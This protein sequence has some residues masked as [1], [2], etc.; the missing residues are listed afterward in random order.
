[1]DKSPVFGIASQMPPQQ[2]Q[3]QTPSAL[4]T[5]SS[6]KKEYA[7][8]LRET[9]NRKKFPVAL[10]SNFK[11]APLDL[12]RCWLD[13]GGDWAQVSIVVQRGV[14]SRTKSLSASDGV[15]LRDMKYSD[16]K[17]TRV[18][19]QCVQQGLWMWDPHFVGDVEERIYFPMN[20]FAWEKSSS[21][22]QSMTASAN[23]QVDA[24]EAPE[25]FGEDGVLSAGMMAALPSGSSLTNLVG[26]ADLQ[27]ASSGTP[28]GTKDSKGKKTGK[29]TVGGASGEEGPAPQQVPTDP[30][31]PIRKLLVD[32]KKEA[33]ESMSLSV[34]LSGKDLS[35]ELE[36][37]LSRHSKYLYLQC[38]KLDD[39]LQSDANADAFAPL[40]QQLSAAQSWYS[41]RS[42]SA[43]SLLRPFMASAKAKAK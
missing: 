2:Q 32:I 11:D 16:E 22:F 19:E 28:G 13:H 17:K 26:V 18:V 20:R 21:T 35:R 9:K 36:V 3:Q 15:K 34:Q 29:A 5:S 14:E 40:L 33:G 43:K 27:C 30:L 38:K 25:L 39:L 4:P 31:V 37:Q 6:H 8:F 24:D 41:T 10:S 23:L 7:T 12:F 1:M 42:K